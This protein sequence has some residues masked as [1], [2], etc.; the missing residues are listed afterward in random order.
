MSGCE[1]AEQAFPFGITTS[2]KHPIQT[3]AMDTGR[4]SGFLKS[5]RSRNMVKGQEKEVGVIMLIGVV[6]RGVQI[7]RRLF[8]I[9]RPS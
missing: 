9:L 4:L 5:A 7:R 1:H 2:G 6:Q 8:R 3:N